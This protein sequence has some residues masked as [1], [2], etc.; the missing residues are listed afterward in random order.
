[1]QKNDILLACFLSVFIKV[2]PHVCVISSGT[3]FIVPFTFTSNPEVVSLIPAKIECF[4]LAHL[5]HHLLT[6]ADAQ[7]EINW[8]TYIK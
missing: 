8:F 5:V 6:S 3:I 7:Q 4:S 1:M 2:T